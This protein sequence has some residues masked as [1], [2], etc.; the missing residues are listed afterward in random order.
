MKIC[1]ISD[2]H[3]HHNKVE[4][5]ECDILIH[6]GDATH[7]GGTKDTAKFVNWL[8]AQD[9]AKHKVFIAGNHDFMPQTDPGQFYNLLDELDINYLEDSYV[10]LEG[11]NIYGTPWTPY[12]CDWAFNGLE[13]RGI[14]GYMYQGGPGPMNPSNKY[15]HLKDVYAKIPDDTDVLI[16]HGPPAGIGISTTEEGTEVGSFE[17]LHRA[18]DLKNLKLGICGH[19]HEGR[20]H[21]YINEAYWYNVSTCNR[22]Y[23]AVNPVTIIE[24]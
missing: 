16:C 24:L 22:A 21:S 19:I 11:L 5:P 20:G 12:F 2:T 23:K 7:R 10:E 6:A 15:Q 3:T 14:D 9:Q 1:A 4:V 17:L 18:L 13:E 8:A